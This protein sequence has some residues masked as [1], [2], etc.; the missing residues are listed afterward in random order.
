[1][2]HLSLH[3]WTHSTARST[4]KFRTPNHTTESMIPS[5]VHSIKPKPTWAG[6]KIFK[7]ASFKTAGATCKKPSW[8]TTTHSSN[9]INNTILA[10]YRLTPVVSYAGPVGPWKCRLPWTYQGHQPCY[11]M[12]TP[13]EV[14]YHGHVQQC[15]PEPACS[16]PPYPH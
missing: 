5:L 12:R 15:C 1:M 7:A 8:Q 9:W 2:P 13:L 3:S 16:Q 6:H 10:Q 14:Y 4:G 11:L